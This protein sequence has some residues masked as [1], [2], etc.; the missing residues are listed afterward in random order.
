MNARDITTLSSDEIKKLRR[1]EN[2]FSE[3]VISS[4]VYGVTGCVVKGA[5][6]GTLYKIT[7][8]NSNLFYII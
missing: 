3:V 7:S 6:T 1:E 8:R 5:K 4:G 2:Y